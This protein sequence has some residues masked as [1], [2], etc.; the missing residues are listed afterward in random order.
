MIKLSIDEIE[1]RINMSI[2][3]NS[4][5]TRLRHCEFLYRFAL[6]LF[7]AVAKDCMTAAMRKI[8][9]INIR[10]KTEGGTRWLT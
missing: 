6:L 5:V 8:N 3:K 4:E 9:R 10:K 7:H 2:K 1:R